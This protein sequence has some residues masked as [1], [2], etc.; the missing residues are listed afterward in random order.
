MRLDCKSSRTGAIKNCYF[1]PLIK[2]NTYLCHAT[3]KRNGYLFPEKESSLFFMVLRL[4]HDWLCGVCRS[5]SFFLNHLHTVIKFCSVG[6]QILIFIAA[7]LQIQQN[8]YFFVSL[9]KSICQYDTPTEPRGVKKIN[10]E[11]VKKALVPWYAM[12][13]ITTVWHFNAFSERS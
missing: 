10:G 2:T 13:G 11:N 3:K 6:L 9:N 7:G 4:F 8:K 12:G 1:F 5:F